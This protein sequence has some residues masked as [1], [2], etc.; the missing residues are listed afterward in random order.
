MQ[1]KKYELHKTKGKEWDTRNG[2]FLSSYPTCRPVK[3]SII[4]NSWSNLASSLERTGERCSDM[5]ITPTTLA[6]FLQYSCKYY[7]DVNAESGGGS[8]E[9]NQD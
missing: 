3:P 2:Y 8:L 5:T 1:Q 4:C 7:C 9:E 6:R